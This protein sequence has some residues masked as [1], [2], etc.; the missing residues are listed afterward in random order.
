MLANYEH[1]SFDKGLHI[2]IE[3]YRGLRNIPHWHFES[4]LVVCLAGTAC[5]MLE[6]NTYELRPGFCVF[7]SSESI[8]S[9]AG[10]EDSQLIVAQFEAPALRNLPEY[11]LKTPLF[12]DRYQVRERMEQIYREYLT[13]PPFYAE[14]VNAVMTQLTV[15][16]LR[17]EEVVKWRAGEAVSLLRYKELLSE[18]DQHCDSLSFSGAAQFMSMSEAYFSRFFKRVSGMTF[19]QYLNVVRVSRAIDLLSDKPDLPVRELLAETGFNTIRNFN[20]VFKSVT[21][22]SPKQLPGDYILH[23]RSLTTKTGFFDPTLE[24]SEVLSDDI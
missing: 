4:E 6:G 14:M 22:Y 1:R 23:I 15:D 20:R 3:K 12:Q 24:S 19:S 7:C 8:H 21:G 9:I 2:W 13:K 5:V 18:I 16:I 11:R 10:S 17:C